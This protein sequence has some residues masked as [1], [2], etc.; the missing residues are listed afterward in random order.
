MLS[1]HNSYQYSEKHDYWAAVH[2][3]IPSTHKFFFFSTILVR[4][5]KRTLGSS[6]PN[7]SWQV[8]TMF[9]SEVFCNFMNSLFTTKSSELISRFLSGHT[10][11]PNIN[12]GVHL[13]LISSKTV[14]SDT[15]LPTL[16][17]IALAERYKE[18]FAELIEHVNILEQV[19][20]IPIYRN[21]VTHE[22]HC[23]DR[24]TIFE[25]SLCGAPGP[26]CT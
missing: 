24:L 10:S 8:L 15:V 16:V 12:A 3:V 9:M 11:I 22:I 23:P 26:L 17:N 25:Y 14:S 19:R 5:A 7:M 20:K 2:F 1:K 4:V 6:K 13:V 21:S 18:R